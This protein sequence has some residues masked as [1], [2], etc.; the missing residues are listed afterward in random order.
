MPYVED[1]MLT[2]FR[3]DAFK[4]LL[5]TEYD[6]SKGLYT[7]V[8]TVRALP[9]FPPHVKAYAGLAGLGQVNN[10]ADRIVNHKDPRHRREYPS[11]LHTMME[12][13]GSDTTFVTMAIYPDDCHRGELLLGEGVLITGLGLYEC[14]QTY[15][16]LAAIGVPACSISGTVELDDD[17]SEA[18]AL[19][20]PS[21]GMNGEVSLR[22]GIS[23]QSHSNIDVRNRARTLQA[24]LTTGIAVSWGADVLFGVMEQ[25]KIALGK[26]YI[27]AHPQL[28]DSYTGIL[29]ASITFSQPPP[30]PYLQWNSGRAFQADDTPARLQRFGLWFQTLAPH[31]C[32]LWIAARASDPRD[33]YKESNREKAF[34][35]AE[36]LTKYFGL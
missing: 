4:E 10:L 24:L 7:A 21:F 6:I 11:E 17:D 16:Q 33:K 32:G 29:V 8:V 31:E 19:H 9:N 36:L 28:K 22:Y 26:V 25:R 3:R 2:D 13:P 1:L 34:D 18:G 12:L 23:T 27:K 14:S 15:A 30:H 20:S 35:I 5:K